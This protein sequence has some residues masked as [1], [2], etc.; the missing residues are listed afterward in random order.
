MRGHD[1]LS[2]VT[3][4]EVQQSAINEINL[5]AN[6]GAA[7]LASGL[8]CARLI[9]RDEW[10]QYF[11]RSCVQG[12]FS[13]V[14]DELSVAVMFHIDTN[15]FSAAINA[16]NNNN[17]EFFDVLFNFRRQYNGILRQEAE[18]VAQYDGEV[19]YDG[20][21]LERL[22]ASAAIWNA[23]FSTIDRF[24][25]IREGR[26]IL[27]EHDFEVMRQP[28]PVQVSGKVLTNLSS[29]M[30]KFIICG[31][32]AA[33]EQDMERAYYYFAS[34]EVC[35][36]GVEYDLRATGLVDLANFYKQLI[37]S[38]QHIGSRKFVR[39]TIWK[40]AEQHY[41]ALNAYERLL[42][43]MK[44]Y[45]DERD[46]Y[47]N[48]LT[49]SCAENLQATS[50]YSDF[51][52]DEGHFSDFEILRIAVM[53][54]KIYRYPCMCTSDGLH[55]ARQDGEESAVFAQF[56]ERVEALQGESSRAHQEAA[57]VLIEQYIGRLLPE[58]IGENSELVSLYHILNGVS[59]QFG[60]CLFWKD[61]IPDMY[62]NFDDIATCFAGTL[63]GV[64]ELEVFIDKMQ[65][66]RPIPVIN[67]FI[68]NFKKV[69]AITTEVGSLIR[70][71]P[72]YLNLVSAH[73]LGCNLIND[74]MQIKLVADRYINI[75][76]RILQSNDVVIQ[77]ELLEQ[78]KESETSQA[79][80][81]LKC[82]QT[83]NRNQFSDN[84]RQ[85]A[86]SFDRGELVISYVFMCFIEYMLTHNLDW[87]KDL[88]QE[89]LTTVPQNS[90]GIRQC[91][92]LRQ[93]SSVAERVPNYSQVGNV[94]V[95]AMFMN[96][97][98]PIDFYPSDHNVFTTTYLRYFDNLIMQRVAP[99]VAGLLQ[100]ETVYKAGEVLLTIVY[101]RCSEA[102]VI[103]NVNRVVPFIHVTFDG[104]SCYITTSVAYKR[105]DFTV[106]PYACNADNIESDQKPGGEV[107]SNNKRRF[108]DLLSNES[109]RQYRNDV[110]LRAC[111]T[112]LVGIKS[113]SLD[114]RNEQLIF[115]PYVRSLAKLFNSHG[116]EGF[117][118]ANKTIVY[119]DKDLDCLQ[120]LIDKQIA[121]VAVSQDQRY[122]AIC[123]LGDVYRCLDIEHRYQ[124][125]ERVK[126][127]AQQQDLYN[128]V[129]AYLV[130]VELGELQSRNSAIGTYF[131]FFQ[132]LNI[133]QQRYFME[134][135]E[136]S[137]I[138]NTPM[139]DGTRFSWL[140]ANLR[141]QELLHQAFVLRPDNATHVARHLITI[142][143][144]QGD[145]LLLS[146]NV[147]S[148]LVDEKGDFRLP[149]ADRINKHTVLPAST[150]CEYGS[151]EP[152]LE[153]RFWPD[154]PAYMMQRFSQ[155]LVGDELP[156][157]TYFAMRF[158]RLG[159]EARDLV[160]E[161]MPH[162]T[163]IKLTQAGDIVKQME[164]AEVLIGGVENSSSGEIA[165]LDRA[166]FTRYLLLS[167]VCNFEDA[168]DGNY[169]LQQDGNVCK[170]RMID[171]ELAGREQPDEDALVVKNILYFMKHMDSGNY[172]DKGVVEEFLALDIFSVMKQ[173]LMDCQNENARLYGLFG[174]DIAKLY[175]S[176]M[177]YDNVNQTV[178]PLVIT[179]FNS[180][181]L[182]L[183]VGNYVALFQRRLDLL[184]SAL[185]MALTPIGAEITG[186]ELMR[187]VHG[188]SLYELCH[189][190]YEKYYDRSLFERFRDACPKDAYV[191]RE[192]TN[193]VGKKVVVFD[194]LN[195]GH[196]YIVRMST[197]STM[198][199]FASVL[200]NAGLSLKEMY[201]P[202]KR[203]PGFI[204]GLM[205]RVSAISKVRTEFTASE[206]LSIAQEMHE[207]S[208]SRALANLM[209]QNFGHEKKV[210]YREIADNV[211]TN[212]NIWQKQIGELSVQQGIIFFMQLHK[213]MSTMSAV[214]FTPNKSELF[215]YLRIL[216]LSAFDASF[217]SGYVSPSEISKYLRDKGWNLSLLSLADAPLTEIDL[218]LER[219]QKLR[220]IALGNNND[221]LLDNISLQLL[222]RNE[223][224]KEVRKTTD[225]LRKEASGLNEKIEY[226]NQAMLELVKL[227]TEADDP[228]S[229]LNVL[230]RAE[231]EGRE[232]IRI[233][234]DVI[235]H[236]KGLIA[237]G[238][239]EERVLQQPLLTLNT[240]SLVLDELQRDIARLELERAEKHQQLETILVN[241]IGF[242]NRRRDFERLQHLIADNEQ[243]IAYY[244]RRRLQVIL[245]GH[246]DFIVRAIIKLQACD[247]VFEV[248]DVSQ[249]QIIWLRLAAVGDYAAF[250]KIKNASLMRKLS[251]RGSASQVSDMVYGFTGNT[252]GCELEDL[253]LPPINPYGAQHFIERTPTLRVIRFLGGEYVPLENWRKIMRE[254]NLSFVRALSNARFILKYN[255][256]VSEDGGV[257]CIGNM[258]GQIIDLPWSTVH[259]QVVE[260]PGGLILQSGRMVL[261]DSER[262]ARS[263][264]AA[265]FIWDRNGK[266]L[267]THV[268]RHD[269]VRI[270]VV[271][272]NFLLSLHRD[273][274]GREF[275]CFW[276]VGYRD[277]NGLIHQHQIA[278]RYKN[279][280]AN[281]YGKLL[282][283]V[284]ELNKDG[285]AGFIR[286][287]NDRKLPEEQKF[288]KAIC[289]YLNLGPGFGG[290]ER[291]TAFWLKHNDV[292]IDVLPDDIV[293]DN[294]QDIV[295]RRAI[296]LDRAF[297]SARMAI[298]NRH[299]SD[300][301]NNLQVYILALAEDD[302][303]EE[304]S[305]LLDNLLSHMPR[306]LEQQI[307]LPTVNGLRFWLLDA[308]RLEQQQRING[309]YLEDKVNA[310][311]K[312]IIALFERQKHIRIFRL[313][314][315]HSS[316]EWKSYKDAWEAEIGAR[317]EEQL[318]VVE[319]PRVDPLGGYNARLFTQSQSRIT[320]NPIESNGG[321]YGDVAGDDLAQDE[322]LEDEALEDD[323]MVFNTS[324]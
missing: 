223:R 59:V 225:G 107:H 150:E 36:G 80:A 208:P 48:Y 116:A 51:Y 238:R 315:M 151:G 269:I 263:P 260:L 147:F 201:A 302:C 44:S 236:V 13:A 310:R 146:P 125:F 241:D 52:D 141:W 280:I 303:N 221:Q 98:H 155:L 14:D 162:V 204:G 82:L 295:M 79:L 142:K 27:D 312:A 93:N 240:Q 49:S 243:I 213:E 309:G 192:I 60:S 71:L 160:V 206:V 232:R 198:V 267:S 99:Y 258:T 154:I 185:E 308:E 30:R 144:Q 73:V 284:A 91:V 215:K 11:D 230:R 156:H 86:S 12:C 244:T 304:L 193:L 4:N 166:S 291:L 313:A 209:Q 306:R 2:R 167:L 25:R 3:G 322:V 311:A 15:L 145:N 210:D 1:E 110:V 286:Y 137:A 264:D 176:E 257:L 289:G 75:G 249:L 217:Y 112:V 211:T 292:L 10:Q 248:A 31:I 158:E 123:A 54:P 136:G 65:V 218:S 42:V 38:Q 261:T 190:S 268:V 186:Y 105:K 114:V 56:L 205:S 212:N 108:V 47:G 62:D 285:L 196:N 307:E 262:D 124:L 120:S 67:T 50:F 283:I 90:A 74:D 117:I 55:Y 135:L 85:Q 237:E 254:R 290:Y 316:L 168:H 222:S 46:F 152:N 34:V 252:S 92:L 109:K 164:S 132:Y 235:N 126:Q 122:T 294:N 57:E 129:V 6:D 39:L 138:F 199:P 115:T 259:N 20:V 200:S 293:L 53:V 72:E 83:L 216:P 26:A 265:F 189:T 234:K 298:V 140:L 272:R 88:H 16:I 324:G 299:I 179:P 170:L 177:H 45:F 323:A 127:Q 163:G 297:A 301:E 321:A 220:K 165:R 23:Y 139:P 195:E 227:Q 128:E 175:N 279:I 242:I 266:L 202:K 171:F 203:R 58:E 121:A 256:P 245:T 94:D 246:M 270:V 233:A 33:Q 84:Y 239:V 274:N 143:L 271:L 182:A 69:S 100:N 247:V 106:L 169:F 101:G 119:S 9:T 253:D 113:G 41:V 64:K 19:D 70:V 180:S 282:H 78:L 273:D 191:D 197:R 194:G 118:C 17:T 255:N 278:P 320:E 251:L 187:R 178:V 305:Y 277:Q 37:I 68:D 63:R 35:H 224:L 103:V 21:E 300:V 87:V 318:L 29:L 159:Y 130:Q 131:M 226:H 97:A 287:A 173:W 43:D 219:M 22:V 296:D 133:V 28:L 7:V 275:L 95:D 250:A 5:G 81:V 172:I 76:I 181:L 66:H 231:L 228:Q 317:Q 314:D 207:L 40:I 24:M 183:P 281:D 319:E 149:P 153:F 77:N 104:E 214:R 32:K 148:W 8:K 157:S 102:S 61:F 111:M 288:C 134:A 229:E 161:V 188:R 89:L 18:D 96:I 276:H 184:R 174:D